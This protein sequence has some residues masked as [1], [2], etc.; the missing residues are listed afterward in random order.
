MGL[1]STNETLASPSLQPFQ[2]YVVNLTVRYNKQ[3]K[4][5]L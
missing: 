1:L 2:F 5:R 4:N 3:T